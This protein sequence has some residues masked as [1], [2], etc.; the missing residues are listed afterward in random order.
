[1]RIHIISFSLPTYTHQYIPNRHC[2][3]VVQD[4]IVLLYVKVDSRTDQSRMQSHKLWP[5]RNRC[6]LSNRS[7]KP[8][9]TY[10]HHASIH[11]WQNWYC[12]R[13]RAG[14]CYPLKAPKQAELH[15]IW[16]ESG[17]HLKLT[18]PGRIELNPSPVVKSIN[19]EP[20]T[21]AGQGCA[22]TPQDFDAWK[23]RK[24]QPQESLTTGD[25]TYQ[26]T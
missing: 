8:K 1:M 23:D 9:V 25:T 20:P 17:S 13:C 21:C 22:H 11:T 5:T 26:G 4:S 7:L 16:L 6:A 18:L 2:P 24:D 3:G 19:Q 15:Y 14:Y 12:P 10:F